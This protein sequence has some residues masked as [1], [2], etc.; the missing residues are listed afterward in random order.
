MSTETTN[1]K[2]KIDNGTTFGRT[3]TD[4]AVDEL[5]KGVGGGKL[6]SIKIITDISTGQ[7]TAD[8]SNKPDGIYYVDLGVK[9]GT[10]YTEIGTGVGLGKIGTVTDLDT[11]DKGRVFA[12]YGWS[13]T[14]SIFSGLNNSDTNIVE[15]LGGEC[16]LQPKNY[17]IGTLTILNEEGQLETIDNP[18]RQNKYLTYNISTNK[19]E[20]STPTSDNSKTISLSSANTPS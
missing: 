11:G 16:L 5:L 14:F 15:I 1:K 9:L 20:W 6:D 18:T 12:G 19:Y 7:I 4:K 13:N 17:A 3:Y 8:I 2:I 10:D